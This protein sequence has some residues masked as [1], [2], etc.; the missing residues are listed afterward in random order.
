M[1]TTYGPEWTIESGS[2]Y[3]PSRGMICCPLC[4]EPI[5]VR[6]RHAVIVERF[7]GQHVAGRYAH[8]ECCRE[9]ASA[10]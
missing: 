9:L 10:P 3:S 6:Q 8:V 7:E 2:R 5:D 4:D 1:T